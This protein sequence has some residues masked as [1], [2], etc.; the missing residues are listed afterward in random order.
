MQ[1]E[2]IE[3]PFAVQSLEKYSTDIYDFFLLRFFVCLKYL[4]C[5]IRRRIVYI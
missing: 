4:L 5:L 1:T 3:T 2:I